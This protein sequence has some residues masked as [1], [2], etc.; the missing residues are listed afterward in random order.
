MRII[1][2]HFEFSGFDDHLVKAGTSVY[3]WNLARQFKAA[4]HETGAVTAAHGLLP[5]IA[6]R[7][8]VTPL[9][10][11]AHE[12][13]P[14]RLDPLHWPHF[15][16]ATTLDVTAR[17]HRVTVDGIDIVMLSGG[18]LDAFPD[19]F[20]PPRELEGHSLDFLKPLV[21]QVM[22]ARYVR[23]R[24]PGGT[25]VHLHEPFHHYLLPGLLAGHGF[26]VVSTV[27]TNM[28]VNTKVYGPQVRAVLEHMGA[29]PS[30]ADGLADPPLDSR[31]E[32]AMRAFLPRTLLYKDYPER[33]EHD[34]ITMLGLVVR[35]V[36]AMDFLSEGQLDHALTQ[37]ETPFEE[38]F[39]Q[40][41][42]RRELRAHEDLLVIGGCAIGDEWLH[43]QRDEEV[44]KRTLTALGL[45]P[46]LPTLFHNA[47]Y[48]VQHKGQKELFRGIRALLDEGG[49]CN[50]LLHCL[51][52]QPP[53]DPD[54]DALARD[55]ADLVRVDTG[56][57]SNGAIKDWAVSSDFCVFP[58]KFEM[59]TF[60]M[61]MG[62]AMASGSVPVA[63][64]QRG[65]RHFRHAVDLD[66][67]GATGLALPRSFRVDD[68][69]LTEAVRAG[70]E[71]MLRV[72]HEEPERMAVLRDRAVEVARGFTWRAAALR[73]LAV[74]E[75]VRAGNRPADAAPPMRG[76]PQTGAEPFEAGDGRAV[77]DDGTV[78]VRWWGRDA[79]RV[80]VVP[81][82]PDSDVV[83][84]EPDGD[85][86]AGRV[87]VPADGVLV[88]LV[89][90]ADGRTAWSELAV[91]DDA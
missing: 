72:W 5:L 15:P 6:E 45:D 11:S 62:E 84:L 56:P 58:S 13:I 69:L 87:R 32:R 22:A 2:C 21:F 1:E 81:P 8:E 65:M 82:D 71:R 10:W 88:I 74:F 40:L 60:L 39:Q 27:Q 49:R 73:F 34:Y 63:T 35:S 66:T 9:D 42:V 48:S 50:V 41:A 23:E 12:R 67:P 61:A 31:L 83:A 52:P 33:P 26:H 38:L 30:V 68:P 46:A 77:C 64:A 51:A 29:D 3:L 44:R 55:Y 53:D 70:L 25:M 75:A 16:E 57:M 91:A 90:G 86:F 80:E 24:I 14:V 79:R 19:S 20:Y 85:G 7:Y 89:T 47:R 76:T 18:V 28:A 43:V 78:R 17:A 54:L 4:G 59:D 37:A 36:A